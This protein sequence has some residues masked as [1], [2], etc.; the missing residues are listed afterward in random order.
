M[1]IIVLVARAL[2][3]DEGNY[4]GMSLGPSDAPHVTINFGDPV[5]D[6]ALLDL[7]AGRLFR[8]GYSVYQSSTIDELP[9]SIPNLHWDENDMLAR[10][11]VTTKEN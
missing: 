2:E 11:P 1:S 9:E 6:Y 8:M 7:L 10:K 3:D 5:V 4:A